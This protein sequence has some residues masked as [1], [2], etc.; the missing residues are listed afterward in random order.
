[1][2][3]LDVSELDVTVGHGLERAAPR[4]RDV[5]GFEADPSWHCSSVSRLGWR[6]GGTGWGGEDLHDSQQDDTF[7][8]L[9]HLHLAGRAKIS[10]PMR[11]F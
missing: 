7:R 10:G 4:W 9:S 11:V 8:R 2:T 3:S 5:D 6:I 1:M